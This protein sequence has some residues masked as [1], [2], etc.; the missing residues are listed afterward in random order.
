M[1]FDYRTYTGPGKQV[2][3]RA[4]TKP[5]VHQDP[6][7]RSSDPTRDL[8]RLVC[9]CPEIPYGLAIPLLGIY[10]KKK[11][12]INNLKRYINLNVYSSIVS[13]NQDM[14]MARVR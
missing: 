7:E 4:Q 12:T 13:N 5:C 1:G 14:K 6:G 8:A 2:F 10:L 9:E 11:K 3:L